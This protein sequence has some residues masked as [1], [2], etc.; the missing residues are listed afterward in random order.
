MTYVIIWYAQINL[1]STEDQGYVK[2]IK[3]IYDYHF[4]KN[5]FYLHLAIVAKKCLYAVMPKA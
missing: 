3:S 2:N 1:C 4:I 5:L